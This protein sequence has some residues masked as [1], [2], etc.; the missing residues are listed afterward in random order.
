MLKL[1]EKSVE[2]QNHM[3]DSVTQKFDKSFRST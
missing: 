3:Y 1:E 2:I